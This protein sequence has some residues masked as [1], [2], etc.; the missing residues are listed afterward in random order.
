MK[1]DIISTASVSHFTK[2]DSLCKILKSK[3]F[4]PHYCLENFDYLNWEKVIGEKISDGENPVFL[5]NPIV[6]FTDLPH[7]KWKIHKRSY[8][9]CIIALRKDWKLRNKLSP[10]IYLTKNDLLSDSLFPWCLKMSILYTNEL[11]KNNVLNADGYLNFTNFL[12]AYLKLY[13]DDH[14]MYYDEREWRF[15]PWQGMSGLPMC[16]NEEQ[17]NNS[18]LLHNYYEQIWKD[19][20]NLLFFDFDD[21]ELIEVKTNN[22]KDKVVD[23]LTKYFGVTRTQAN[24]IINVEQKF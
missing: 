10:V 19:N 24:K 12:I 8:G 16:L 22:Q 15:V 1:K 17:Y 4:L 9:T 11:K 5:A 13:E 21:I 2:F 18:N 20:R 14:H 7:D 6:C 3:C 23:I